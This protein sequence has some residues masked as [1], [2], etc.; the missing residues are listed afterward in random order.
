MRKFGRS[1]PSDVDARLTTLGRALEHDD[2][3]LALYLVGSRARGEE[4]AL[5]DIDLALLLSRSVDIDEQLRYTNQVIDVLG[6]DDV[7]VMFVRDLP[8]ALADH[9]LR[10]GKVLLSRDEAARVDF[11]QRIHH[12][13]LDFRPYLRA[14]DQALFRDVGSWGT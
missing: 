9:V 5:S 1:V 12:R 8:L 7:S 13:Y 10:D 3:V 11:E 6:T 4:D 14:Y 2:A